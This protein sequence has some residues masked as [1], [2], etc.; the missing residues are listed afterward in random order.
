MYFHTKEST[1]NTSR[2][3][4]DFSLI[5]TNRLTCFGYKDYTLAGRTCPY[6][7]ALW[8]EAT[9]NKQVPLFVPVDCNTLQEAVYKVHK[10]VCLTAIVL[11]KG[12]HEI[13]GNCLEIP[14]A[15]NIVGDPSVSKEKIVVLGGIRFKKGMQGNCHLQHL[16]LRQA[17]ETGVLGLSSFTMDEVLVEQCGG[18]G[19]IAYGTGVVGRCTNVK[20]HQ[21]GWGGMSARDGGSVTLIGARTTVHHNCTHENSGNFGLEVFGSSLSTIQLVSPLTKEHV[22][23]DNGGGG[24]WGADEDGNI[25]QIKTIVPQ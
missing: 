23:V 9:D 13:N 3:P 2:V 25:N 20:V 10:E 17:K 1:T 22:A 18:Y 19:V 24:N 4:L 14:S 16:I 6:L 8:M 15:M 5:S 12:E 11:M 7:H 21:C